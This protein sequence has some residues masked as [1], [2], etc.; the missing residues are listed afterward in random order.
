MNTYP[1]IILAFFVL[2]LL[3]DTQVFAYR[4]FGEPR[5]RDFQRRETY[6]REPINRHETR[7]NNTVRHPNAETN[8]LA[9]VHHEKI[10]T[11]SQQHLTMNPHPGIPATHPVNN[12]AQN[13]NWNNSNNGWYN[14]WNTNWNNWNRPWG[15]TYNFYGN[16]GWAGGWGWGDY[17]NGLFF[18]AALGAT[19]GTALLSSYTIYNPPPYVYPA[20]KYSAATPTSTTLPS[21]ETW[22]S[23]ENGNV[24]PKAVINNT[25]NGKSTYYC[26]A[27]YMNQ[28]TY[29]VLVANDGCYIETSSATMRFTTYDVLIKK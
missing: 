29:G 8:T 14:H 10:S 9:T 4:D 25:D 17:Y 13:T 15:N 7:Y 22:V 23:A 5:E 3:I 21:N 11:F 12:T 19:L 28:L 26:R 24:P 27:N 16:G 6:R 1:K 18:G 2:Q 20:S